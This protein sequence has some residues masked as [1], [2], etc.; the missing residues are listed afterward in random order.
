M[1]AEWNLSV[2]ILSKHVLY[3]CPSNISHSW[4]PE[5]KFLFSFLS[6]PSYSFFS[7]YFLS[8]WSVLHDRSHFLAPQG[9]CYYHHFKGKKIKFKRWWVIYMR[10]SNQK[11]AQVRFEPYKKVKLRTMDYETLKTFFSPLLFLCSW[12][13]SHAPSGLTKVIW[14]AEG[15]SSQ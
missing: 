9:R 12:F 13:L 3:G 6:K 14:K 1:F 7:Q 11:V 15:H 10:L 4:C 5:T 2:L 8:T